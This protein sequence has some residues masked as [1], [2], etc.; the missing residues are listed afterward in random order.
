MFST[1]AQRRGNNLRPNNITKRHQDARQPPTVKL[2]RVR[3]ATV[4]GGYSLDAGKSGKFIAEFDRPAT[5][6]GLV[7]V[8][9]AKQ[10][11]RFD[12]LILIQDAQINPG[13]IQSTQRIGLE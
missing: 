2:K 12:L 13:R 4:G 6:S 5:R 1:S 3:R 11:Y 8:C 9:I 7:H 10:V